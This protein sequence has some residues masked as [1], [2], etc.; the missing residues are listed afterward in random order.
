[1]EI[2]CKKWRELASDYIEGSLPEPMANAMQAHTASCPVCAA[3]ESALRGLMHELN[4]LPEVDPPLYFHENVMSAIQREQE[5]RPAGPWWEAWLPRVA[6]TAVG[7]LLAG[8]A[9]A[10]FLY[11]VVLPQQESQKKPQ[12]AAPPVIALL[13]GTTSETGPAE[14]ARLLISRNTVDVKNRGNAYSFTFWMEN[15]DRGTARFDIGG[16]D[17]PFRFTLSANRRET[18]QVPFD[19]LQGRKTMDLRV[20]WMADGESHIR[21]IVLPVPQEK[22]GVLASERQAFGLPTSDLITTVRELAV[23]YGTPITL[24]DVATGTPVTLVARNE[25]LPEALRRTL[26]PQGF[27]VASTAGGILIQSPRSDAVDR[28]ASPTP[29]P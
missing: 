27:R 15:S 6:R 3:D 18:L 8:G 4:A 26:G 25:T 17:Q 14:N 7:T 22:D 13:P 12:M 11:A 24:D 9:A 29:T 16:V 28:S 23:R 1:M 10:A 5:Q 2:T 21:W 19:V 20:Q